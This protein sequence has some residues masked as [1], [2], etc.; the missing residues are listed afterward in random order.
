MDKKKLKNKDLI[1]PITGVDL[2]QHIANLSP[3]ER[4]SEDAF[5][6]IEYTK[7]IFGNKNKLP[8]D[9]DPEIKGATVAIDLA[10]HRLN[11]EKRNQK[12]I[13]LQ[14]KINQL[15]GSKENIARLEKSIADIQNKLASGGILPTRKDMLKK[16]LDGLDRILAEENK[17][18]FMGDQEIEVI[19]NKNYEIPEGPG[20]NIKWN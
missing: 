1:S 13:D 5:A 17:N 10:M 6:S 12:E 16:Q 14:E 9:T 4:R 18:I 7:N 15:A 8:D 11:T 19:K 3:E 2:E 20:E